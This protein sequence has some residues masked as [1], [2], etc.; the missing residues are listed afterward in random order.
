MGLEPPTCRLRIGTGED[1]G[2]PDASRHFTSREVTSAPTSP[3][4]PTHPP[5]PTP[6]AALAVHGSGRLVSPNEAADRLG[7]KRSTVYALCAKGELPHVRLGSLIRVDV[8]TFLSSRLRTPRREWL[9]ASA[10]PE[11]SSREPTRTRSRF[12]SCDRAV[13]VPLIQTPSPPRSSI[14]NRP[15]SLYTRAWHRITVAPGTLIKAVRLPMTVDSSPSTWI[16]HLW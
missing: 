15:P 6:F 9:R 1:P 13:R 14:Q 3:N 5:N 8:E 12:A 10:L 16:C 4:V 11:L 2:A 7:I